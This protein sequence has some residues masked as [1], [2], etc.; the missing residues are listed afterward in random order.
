MYKKTKKHKCR[1]KK[2]RDYWVVSCLNPLCAKSYTTSYF[3]EAINEALL[4]FK[5]NRRYPY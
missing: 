2:R 3:M 1:I 4:H 5:L